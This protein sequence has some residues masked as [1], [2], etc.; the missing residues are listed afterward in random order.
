[1]VDV[2]AAYGGKAA[3]VRSQNQRY[4]DAMARGDWDLVER[5]QADANRVGYTLTLAGGG[6]STPISYV[7]GVSDPAYPSPANPN[8][9]PFNPGSFDTSGIISIGVMLLL[10]KFLTGLFRRR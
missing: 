4:K 7:P 9:N 6:S 3:Y 10:F 2:F 5:L 1:M 8:P